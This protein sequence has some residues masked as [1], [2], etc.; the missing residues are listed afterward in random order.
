MAL[1]RR[2]LP[3]DRRAPNAACRTYG[4][5]G[6]ADASAGCQVP[7]VECR[8]PGADRRLERD[9]SLLDLIM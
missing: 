9:G 1:G 2:P 3:D 7:V 6:S 4:R 5:G 8:S